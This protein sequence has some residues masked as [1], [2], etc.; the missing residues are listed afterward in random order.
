[1][2]RNG[3]PLLVSDLNKV[4]AEDARSIAVLANEEGDPDESDAKAVRIVLA[5]CKG[6]K[7]RGHVVV[8]IRDIDNSELIHLVGDAK[9]EIIVSH[10][11]I[12]RLMIQCARQPFL[13]QMYMKLL[14]TFLSFNTLPF[15]FNSG[16]L[17]EDFSSSLPPPL[18]FLPPPLLALFLSTIFRLSPSGGRK[19]GLFPSF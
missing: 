10:D 16:H 14:G 8:E 13:A 19:E 12:G 4:S 17:Q 7:I 11:I 9:V 3:N 2:C 15:I 18:S 6:I 5:L 1:M